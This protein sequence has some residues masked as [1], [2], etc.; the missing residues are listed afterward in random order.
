MLGRALATLSSAGSTAWLDRIK[1]RNNLAVLHGRQGQWRRAEEDQRE[2]IAMAD[3]AVQ[4]DPVYLATMLTNYAQILRKNRHAAEAR[5]IE[6]RAVA[7]RSRNP[8]VDVTELG[9]RQNYLW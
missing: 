1:L 9:R 8:V 3:R 5:A 4:L 2:A 6:A 7:L